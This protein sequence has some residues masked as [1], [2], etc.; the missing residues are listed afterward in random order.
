MAGIG[1]V[2][3]TRHLKD[4]TQ[5]QVHFFVTS[6]KPDVAQFA[7]AVRR[8]WSSENN[9]QWTLHIAFDED[10]SRARTA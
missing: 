3:R 6:L 2:E 9:L 7:D 4:K 1:W 8:H 5:H 10:Y